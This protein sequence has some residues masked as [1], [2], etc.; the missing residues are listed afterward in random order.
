M[1]THTRMCVYVCDVCME[2]NHVRVLAQ[3]HQSFLYLATQSSTKT[4]IT[5]N[6]DC[7]VCM[8]VCCAVSKKRILNPDDHTHVHTHTHTSH[9][10]IESTSA[11]SQGNHLSL[12]KF[13]CVPYQRFSL[14]LSLTLSVPYI[15]SHTR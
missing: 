2:A 6:R 8:R 5:Y 11:N 12:S 7:L 4:I 1:F 10:M 13:Q 9:N 15:H 3:N 14:S